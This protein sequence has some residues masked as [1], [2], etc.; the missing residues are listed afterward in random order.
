MLRRST[1]V[2]LFLLGLRLAHA[3]ISLRQSESDGD[4]AKW[5]EREW[6]LPGFPKEE[7]LMEFDVSAATANRFFIDAK[8][9][10][11]GAD[12]VV[13]FTLVIRT[14]GGATNVSYEGLRCDALEHR[15]Y[16]TGRTGGT[17]G[18]ALARGW[19]P[20]E[21]KPINNHHASLSRNYFCP[22]RSAVRNSGEAREAL[23]RGKHPDAE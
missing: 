3:D 18:K 14:A 16:A 4:E 2:L 20:I 8:S 6:T 19:Q 10:D 5:Q 11:I 22:N 12:N 1:I 9:I 7:E 17:W 21:N 15:L 23:R 13:R